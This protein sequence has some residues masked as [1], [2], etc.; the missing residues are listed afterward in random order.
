MNVPQTVIA[1]S[2]V[3]ILNRFYGDV[4]FELA[5]AIF[6]GLIIGAFT[7]IGGLFGGQFG[8]LMGM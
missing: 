3:E 7:M 6:G 1:N 8:L 5:P 2:V 4:S